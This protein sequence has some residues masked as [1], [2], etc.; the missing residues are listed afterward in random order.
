MTKVCSV[1][2]C[3]GKHFGRGLCQK[4]YNAQRRQSP[5]HQEYKRQYMRQYMAVFRQDPEYR[6]HVRQ[7]TAEYNRT[8]E[9]IT[10]QLNGNSKKRRNYTSGL[11]TVDRVRELLQVTECPYC[12]MPI[13]ED[14][15]HF[16]HIIPFA[17]GGTHTDD[18]VQILCA[19]CN[20]WKGSTTP[21]QFIA[22]VRQMVERNR[23]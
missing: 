21:E 9:G 18:N 12:G 19:Q 15:R 14:N 7:Y 3:G 5:E 2:G 8:P 10:A 6:E 16:D 22:E 1:E 11:V 13:T 17:M 4:H 23:K 20:Q